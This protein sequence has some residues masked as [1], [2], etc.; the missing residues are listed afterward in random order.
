MEGLVDVRRGQ[1]IINEDGEG[2]LAQ[3]K[4][5]LPKL[6]PEERVAEVEATTPRPLPTDV[7]PTETPSA[8]YGREAELFDVFNGIR[9]RPVDVA[10]P[11]IGEK[12]QTSPIIGEETPSPATPISDQADPSAPAR[13]CTASLC[14]E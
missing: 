2:I 1:A 4:A 14:G 13:A 6:T 11:I 8:E 10:K 7:L 5:P 9:R 3:A 12:S